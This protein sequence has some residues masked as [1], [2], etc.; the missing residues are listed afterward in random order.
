MLL[1]S[2][3]ALSTASCSRKDDTSAGKGGNATLVCA[4]AHHGV[5]KNITNAKVYI[6]YNAQDKPAGYDDSATC[7]WTDGKPTATFS[8]LKTG[9]YYLYS[10]GYDTTVTSVVEGGISYQ[11]KTETNQTVT[12]PV[13]EGD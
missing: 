3:L 6:K 7:V 9:N 13:T 4:P 2:A 1:L 11:I 10:N 8:G 5:Y 12:I